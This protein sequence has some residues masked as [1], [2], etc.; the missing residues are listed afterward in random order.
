MNRMPSAFFPFLS[1]RTHWSMPHNT[2]SAKVRVD[3]W[4]KLCLESVPV[5]GV[6]GLSREVGGR[7]L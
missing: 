3:V 4:Y 5:N 1:L 2:A 6:Q 7:P